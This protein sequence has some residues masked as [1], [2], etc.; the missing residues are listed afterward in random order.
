MPFTTGPIE[1]VGNQP[2]NAN[3]A[4]V[5]IL[6][7]TGGTLNGVLRSFRL[8]GTR[9]LIE[10]RNFTVA[11]NASTLVILSLV[12]S[13][14]GQADQYEVEIVP[15]QNGGI[16]SVY[17]VTAQGVIITAQRVLNT[18]LTQIL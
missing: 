14:L 9:T 11:A 4:K 7:R 18:E 17:G 8:D 2:A 10:Q 5:K 12:H 13:T 1:N 6:N 16:Y 15:N 3:R